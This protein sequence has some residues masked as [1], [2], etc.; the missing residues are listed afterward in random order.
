MSEKLISVAGGGGD[1]VTRA[2]ASSSLSIGATTVTITPPSGQRVRLTHLSNEA[3]NTETNIDVIFGST[4]VFS[5]SVN[6]SDP[7]GSGVLTVGSYMTYSQVQPPSGNVRSITG[8]T[9]EALTIE[10]SSGTIVA[11]L[12]YG[13]EFGE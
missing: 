4:T 12:Y 7:T 9:G 8:K 13:Y 6:G 2:V 1:F 10:K 11:T 3:G 5:G